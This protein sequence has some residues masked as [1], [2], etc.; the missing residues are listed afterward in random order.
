[1]EPSKAVLM[2]SG[3]YLTDDH[4]WFSF[5]HEAGHLLLHWDAGS[6][7]LETAEDR[8]SEREA[9]ANQFAADMLLPNEY[10]DRLPEVRSNLRGI[11]RLARDAGVSRGIV[12][13]QLQHR[14]LVKQGHFNDLKARYK[15]H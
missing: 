14:G 4:F 13:G 8:H 7:I 15:W 1:M 3:R 12:V 2:L 10:Q 11:I 6:P 5:F 9:E